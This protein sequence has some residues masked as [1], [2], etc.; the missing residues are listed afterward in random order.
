[1]H[2]AASSGSVDLVKQLLATGVDV[3]V[4]NTNGESVLHTAAIACRAQTA[5][6]L[7]SW[8]CFGNKPLTSKW[9]DTSV[10]S[11]DSSNLF[12]VETPTSSH[13]FPFHQSRLQR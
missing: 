6:A 2:I 7:L 11:R 3:G 1:M 13:C 4:R 10:S 5:E 9:E 8:C 12:P